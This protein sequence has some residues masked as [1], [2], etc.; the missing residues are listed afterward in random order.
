MDKILDSI[1]LWH[2]LMQFVFFLLVIFVMLGVLSE[3]WKNLVVLFRGWPEK[4]LKDGK[5]T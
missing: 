3:A 1:A 4:E 5:T 2:P